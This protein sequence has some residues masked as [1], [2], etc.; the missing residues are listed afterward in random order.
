[1]IHLLSLLLG[2]KYN[3]KKWLTN[4]RFELLRHGWFIIIIIIML[5]M[6]FACAKLVHWCRICLSIIQCALLLPFRV[7]LV[8]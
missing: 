7:D 3:L 5:K 2:A 6:V 4:P 8:S 1:M